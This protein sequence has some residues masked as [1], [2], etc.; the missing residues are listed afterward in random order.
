MHKK[1]DTNFSSRKSKRKGGTRGCFGYEVRARART[2]VDCF[3][4]LQ[5]VVYQS[6]WHLRWDNILTSL[7]YQNFFFA[8]GN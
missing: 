2:S 1:G 8:E 3:A 7:P 4:A 6:E 5:K